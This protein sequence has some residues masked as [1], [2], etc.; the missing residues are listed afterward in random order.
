METAEEQKQLI[1]FVTNA[2]QTLLINPKITAERV[3]WIGG[4]RRAGGDI[5]DY[6][7]LE[8]GEPVTIRLSFNGSV[9]NPTTQDFGCLALY[10]AKVDPGEKWWVRNFKCNDETYKYLYFCE[11]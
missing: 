8:S 2:N 6:F 9:E 1:D 7:W 10:R 3:A 4:L 5:S 11:K